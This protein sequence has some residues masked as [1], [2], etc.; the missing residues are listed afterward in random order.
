MENYKDRFGEKMTSVI[1][2][3]IQLL[4]PRGRGFLAIDYVR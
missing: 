1:F 2:S 4:G 3:Q